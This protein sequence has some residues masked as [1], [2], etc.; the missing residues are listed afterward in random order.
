M[1]KDWRQEGNFHRLKGKS[2]KSEQAEVSNHLPISLAPHCHLCAFSSVSTPVY[3]PIVY[4]WCLTVNHFVK[5]HKEDIQLCS[6]CV[7]TS[8]T[9]RLSQQHCGSAESATFTKAPLAELWDNLHVAFWLDVRKGTGLWHPD[10]GGSADTAV[11]SAT[12]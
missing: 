8:H 7:F 12:C 5:L 3:M 2:G 6:S 10:D 11:L 9:S 1:E 4:L